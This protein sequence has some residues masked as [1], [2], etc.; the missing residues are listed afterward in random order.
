MNNTVTELAEF[1][2]TDSE[3]KTAII[4]MP[5]GKIVLIPEEYMPSNLRFGDTVK[6]IFTGLPSNKFLSSEEE[7]GGFIPQKAKISRFDRE[8]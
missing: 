7:V 2:D 4:R 5:N 1:I 6:M 3:N 8:R